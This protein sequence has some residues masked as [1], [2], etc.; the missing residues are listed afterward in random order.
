MPG[1]AVE[2]V[3]VVSRVPNQPANQL[4]TFFISTTIQLANGLDFFRDPNAGSVP[5]CANH[6]DHEEFDYQITIVSFKL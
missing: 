3:R 1:V 2:N 5:V 6:L 4:R